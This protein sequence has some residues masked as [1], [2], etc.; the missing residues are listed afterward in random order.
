MNID[1]QSL[2]RFDVIVIGGGAAGMMAAISAKKQNPTCDVAI[3][4]RTFELGRKLLTAGAGR[5]NLTNVNLERGPSGYY[6]GDQSSVE[7]VFSQFGYADI[8]HFFDELGV[9][10]YLEVK[11]GKGKIFPKIDHAKTIR[12]MLV[13]YLR[14]L[15]ID[16]YCDTAVTA[17][18]KGEHFTLA[19]SRGEYI[20]S[21][22]VLSAGGKTYP[23]LGS[24]GSGYTIA[25][26][27]GHT[28]IEPVVSAVPVVSKNV[29]SHFLQGEKMEMRAT[30]YI[31]GSEV[32]SARGDVMFTQYGFSGPAIFDI[33]RDFSIRINRDHDFGCTVRL[34]FFPDE[35]EESLLA[36]LEKRWHAFPEYSVAAS[37]WGLVT[38]KVAGGI[39]AALKFPKEKM[40]KELSPDDKQSVCSMLY[41]FESA[42]EATRGWNEGEFTAGGVSLRE[43]DPVTMQSIPTP[44][45]FFA[46]EILDVD[47]AVGGFN[48]SWG[49][50]TGWIAG[51][52]AA[53][54]VIR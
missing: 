10:T 38:Q 24:D 42:V 30:S 36:M 9:P 4:D 50:A 2:R 31:G 20:A 1:P 27:L 39:C 37:L 22:V 13:E 14:F 40:S 45:L 47:G 51:K 6:H 23:A 7:A 34:C 18:T 15:H 41:S 53:L 8:M 35:T 44:G 29:L 33:S 5:G 52:H 25:A 48:L 16:I 17:I 19:T 21:N 28:I 54:S 26:S 32:S 46:G 49:W 12:D 3:L 11:T 43:I